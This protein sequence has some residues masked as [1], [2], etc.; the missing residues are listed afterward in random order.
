MK[1]IFIVGIFSL[2]QTICCLLIIPA[3][4]LIFSQSLV[5]STNSITMDNLTQTSGYVIVEN[6]TIGYYQEFSPDTTGWTTYNFNLAYGGNFRRLLVMSGSITVSLKINIAQADT[7]LVYYYHPGGIVPT[8]AYIKFINPVDSALIDSICYN[9]RDN[10]VEAD[11]LNCWF[12]LGKIVI[13]LGRPGIEIQLGAN[14]SGSFNRLNSD[15]LRLLRSP[16]SGADLEFGN[17]RFSRIEISPTTGDTILNHNFFRDRPPIYFPYTIFN[18]NGHQDKKLMLYN[19]GSSTLN[20]SNIQFLTD[21]F[22]VLESFPIVI[23]PGNKKEITI[24]FSPVEEGIVKDTIVIISNDEKSPMETMP[25]YGEGIAYNFVLNASLNGTEPHWNVPSNAVFY[26][27][28]SNWLSSTASPWPFPIAGGNVFSIV[29]TSSDPSIKAI[30]GFSLPDSLSGQYTLDYSGPAGS[31][32]AAQ[33]ATVDLVTPSYINPNPALGD[34]QRVTDVNL[35]AVQSFNPIWVRVGEQTIF[36]INGGGQTTIGLTNPFQGSD[37]LRVDLI[38]VKKYYPPSLIDIN[39]TINTPEYFSLSQNFPN[40]FNPSTTIR[41]SLAVNG[42]VNI[43][44]YDI[45]SRKVDELVSGF[46][47]AGTHNVNFNAGKELASGIYFYRITTN[48]FSLTRKM[49]LLR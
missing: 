40:P 24:R 1:K 26:T 49:I 32:N 11:R 45:L 25:L 23:N 21:K 37:F 39:N 33:H 30:Y 36:Q 22:L 5:D 42:N 4:E 3:T 48:N 28:T 14:V 29:N 18:W 15:A 46:K 38:R 44:V 12:L 8:N 6:D 47:E 27:T 35:R 31:S 7:Y 41:Y 13:N 10:F 20:I 17:R 19:I 2:G 43:S 16:V 34:T 9:M